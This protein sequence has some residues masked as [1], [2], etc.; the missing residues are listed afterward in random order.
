MGINHSYDAYCFDSAVLLFGS[1]IE[2]KLSETYDDGTPKHRLSDLLK[3][4]IDPGRFS[5]PAGFFA[6]GK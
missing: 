5:D 6:K 2:G 4:E 1:Y 3:E